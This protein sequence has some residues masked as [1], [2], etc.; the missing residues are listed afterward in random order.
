VVQKLYKNLMNTKTYILPAVQKKIRKTKICIY[1]LNG[2]CIRASNCQFAHSEEELKSPPNL[3]K[4]RLCLEY[5]L[6]NTCAKDS[7]CW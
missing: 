3:Y 5:S 2:K 7:Q 4:T 6:N 1:H